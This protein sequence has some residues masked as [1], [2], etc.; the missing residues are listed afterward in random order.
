[1]ARAVEHSE[2]TRRQARIGSAQ[3]QRRS[4]WE[5]LGEAIAAHEE[6]AALE[7][8]EF[9][10]DGECRFIFDL[11]V[12]WADDLRRLLGE[13]G[14]PEEELRAHTERLARLLAFPDGEPYDGSAGWEAVAEA[15]GRVS[16]PVRAGDWAAAAAAAAAACEAWR[17][18][19]DRVI[20]SSYG[21]M[22][23][24]VERFGEES[25]PEMFELVAME[26]FE[27]FFELGDPERHA[28]T[29][30]GS[31]AVLLDTLEAMRTHLST[32]RRDGAPIQMVE[33]ADRWEFEFDPCG[34]GGRAL[35]GDIVEGTPS[36]IEEPYRFGVIEGAY[37]W[38]DGKAGMCVYCNHCQ[39]LYE[40]WTIDRSGIPFL[41]IDPPTAADGVGHD[42]PK[43][44]RY[45]IYKRVE[46]V[47]DEVFERCGRHRTASQ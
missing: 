38:T 5:V 13:R 8:A 46:S 18:L 9:A 4:T 39:Q 27:E 41:V 47:P 19:H 20:D 25:V 42:N 26:H 24:W 2:L 34:S 22:S 6:E 23:V 28:W 17:T 37:D 31:D 1:M 29:E 15:V 32:V 10:L 7:L 33:H 43:R 12:G 30:G 36:R 14:M 44:C 11:L 16:A 21:W 3:D 35:R 45:T 40:Q